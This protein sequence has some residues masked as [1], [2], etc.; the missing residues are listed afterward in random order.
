MT[1]T[2]EARGPNGSIRLA[3][4]LCLVVAGHLTSWYQPRCLQDARRQ[5][6][7]CYS[8]LEVSAMASQP[9]NVLLILMKHKYPPTPAYSQSLDGEAPGT[10]QGEAVGQVF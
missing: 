3:Q 5:A 7:H 9:S 2:C 1:S 10:P 6:T 4:V 8:S